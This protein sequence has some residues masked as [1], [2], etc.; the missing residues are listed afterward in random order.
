MP[1]VRVTS[2]LPTL[3]LENMLGALTSYQSFF[4]NGSTLQ[5]ATAHVRPHTL[6]QTAWAVPS[7]SLRALAH[8]AQAGAGPHVFFFP[9]FFPFEIRLFLPT[10]I[11][12]STGIAGHL[13]T[14]AAQCSARSS[15][16]A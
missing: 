8:Q 11:V 2:V 15:N 14:T 6:Q 3:R 10:A 1:C 7:R 16:Y 4:E 5:P 12:A 13:S 9:P